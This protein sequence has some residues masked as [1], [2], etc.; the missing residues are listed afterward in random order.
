MGKLLI[1]KDGGKNMPFLGTISIVTSK[2]STLDIEQICKFD[3]IFP[4]GRSLH[5]TLSSMGRRDRMVVGFTTTCA[6]GAYDC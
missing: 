5:T 3:W 1:P 4:H 2:H 6:I